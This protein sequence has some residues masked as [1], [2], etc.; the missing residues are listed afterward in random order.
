MDHHQATKKPTEVGLP[1]NPFNASGDAA[2]HALGLGM[3]S[4]AQI[5][6]VSDRERA[7]IA[8]LRA[9]VAETMVYPATPPQSFHS[10]LPERMIQAGIAALSLYSAVPPSAVVPA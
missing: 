8:A 2:G 5:S 7:L 10:F 6:I 1:A 4:V 3:Q 9:I